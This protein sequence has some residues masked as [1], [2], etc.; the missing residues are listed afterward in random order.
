MIV[1]TLDFVF[2]IFKSDIANYVLFMVNV[3]LPRDIASFDFAA[4]V[5]SDCITLCLKYV[6]S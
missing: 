1:Q 5:G 6:D 4:L 2:P 3:V